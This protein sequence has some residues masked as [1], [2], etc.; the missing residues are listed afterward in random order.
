MTLAVSEDHLYYYIYFCNIIG[1]LATAR[2]METSTD[3]V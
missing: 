1:N 3:Y 2:P